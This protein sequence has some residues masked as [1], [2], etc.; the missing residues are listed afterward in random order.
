MSTLPEVTAGTTVAP[1]WLGLN[2]TVS[3]R[4]RK[5]PLL[6][7]VLDEGGRHAGGVGDPH[8]RGLALGAAAT[9]VVSAGGEEQRHNYD[10]YGGH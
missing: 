2:F 5:Q 1:P 6:D 7:A 10:Q 3:L 9:V 8:G 4:F